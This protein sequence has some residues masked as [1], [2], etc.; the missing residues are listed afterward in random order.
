MNLLRRGLELHGPKLETRRK[1]GQ[2]LT[3]RKTSRVENICA[4]LIWFVCLIRVALPQGFATTIGSTGLATDVKSN[5]LREKFGSG[6]AGSLLEVALTWSNFDALNQETQSWIVRLWSPGLPV[7]EVPMIWIEKIGIPIFWSFLFCLVFLWTAGFFLFWRSFVP[8]IGRLPII[9]ISLVMLLSWDFKYLFHYGIFNS[10]GYS[11]I[12]LLFFLFTISL[13]VIQGNGYA[14]IKVA[15]FAGLSLGISTI[16]RHNIDVYLT[17]MT[18]LVSMFYLLQSDTFGKFRY[19]SE[20]LTSLS[21]RIE[22]LSSKVQ[23][24]FLMVSFLTAF[25]VTVPWRVVATIVYSGT[26]G[27]MSSAFGLFG[28]YIWAPTQSEVGAY[29]E[30]YGSNWACKIDLVT[31]NEIAFSASGTYSDKQLLAKGVFAAITNPFEYIKIRSFY[32]IE[33]WIPNFLIEL[34]SESIVAVVLL[35]LPVPLFISLFKYKTRFTLNLL[36]GTLTAAILLQL[37]IVH[38]E[39]RYFISLRL[40]TASF[41]IITMSSLKVKR[42][43][44]NTPRE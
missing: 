14:E 39:S 26:T 36:W 31:C 43:S 44:P 5:T 21:K 24:K 10:E 28:R 11:I 15:F 40:I 37:L 32:F 2:F 41:I 8:L 7:L 6:D 29:W 33:N 42:T 3:S 23:L 27:A 4:S 20:F 9:A 19:R 17:S 1:I 30:S 18:M 22:K 16:I 13:K 25:L 34:D 35:V 38:F 12:F